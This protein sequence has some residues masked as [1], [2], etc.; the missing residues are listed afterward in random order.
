MAT[1]RLVVFFSVPLLFLSG[2]SWPATAIPTFWKYFSYVFP[3]T[4]GINAFVKINS[5]GGEMISV[6]TEWY[7][8]WIQA[9]CYFILTLFVYRYEIISSRRKRIALYVQKK[10][11]LAQRQNNEHHA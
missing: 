11:A 4:F 10:A 5:M 7:A 2:I 1:I 8:L 9:F 3:S 6:K